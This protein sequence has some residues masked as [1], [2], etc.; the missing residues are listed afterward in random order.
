MTSSIH[1]SVGVALVGVFTVFWV[2]GAIAWGRKKTD[3][4][5]VFW[6]LLALCQVLAGVQALIGTLL[7]L[8]GLRPTSWLHYVYGFGPIIA[9]AY[10][11]LY[12]RKEAALPYPYLPFLFAGFVAW[13]LSL[14]AL[15]T[16][17]GIGG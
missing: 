15:M 3:A 7:L 10:A 16:G 4:G 12:A 17:L 6:R 11:H 2:W 13:G 8:L 14:R 9:F 5:S 1:E